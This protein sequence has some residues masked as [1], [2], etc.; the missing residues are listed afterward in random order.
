MVL[1]AVRERDSAGE[2]EPVAQR[3]RGSGNQRQGVGRRM[4][5]QPSAFLIVGGEQLVREPTHV[6]QRGI[7]CRRSVPLAQDEDVVFR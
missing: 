3:T 5:G 2:R 1:G 7:Q 4:R 6:V